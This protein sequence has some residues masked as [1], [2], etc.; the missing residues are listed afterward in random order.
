[1]HTAELKKIP[2]VDKLLTLNRIIEAQLLD[3]I[4]HHKI[5]RTISCV[6]ER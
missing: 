4:Y 2:A 6:D 3:L 5:G 1:M